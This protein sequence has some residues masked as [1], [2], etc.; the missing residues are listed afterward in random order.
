M[1]ESAISIQIGWPPGRRRRWWRGWRSGQR[2]ILGPQHRHRSLEQRSQ[3][4][5]RTLAFRRRWRHQRRGLAPRRRRHRRRGSGDFGGR[6]AARR[7]RGRLGC[8]RC[9]SVM[10]C[11]ET[12]ERRR[13]DILQYI[14][15][16]LW[17]RITL[18]RVWILTFHPDADPDPDSSFKKR[19]KLLKSTKIGSYSIHF[20]LTSANWC[21][22]GS[23]SGSSL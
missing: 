10:N 20:G 6:A 17:I 19:F 14:L 13:V 8:R 4:R 2:H 22:S 3:H 23:G 7:G 5:R 18:M 16:V 21:G 15:P 11:V 9:D 12:R 1:F